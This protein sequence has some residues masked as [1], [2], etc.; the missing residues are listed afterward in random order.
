LVL[1]SK[2]KEHAGIG[3][4]RFE[5][6]LPFNYA[7]DPAALLQKLLRSFLIGPEVR[8]RRLGFDSL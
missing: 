4:L 8:R 3:N 5:L 7:F 2:F 1:F 6:F